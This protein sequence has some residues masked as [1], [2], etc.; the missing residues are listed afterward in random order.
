M[1]SVELSSCC[2][3]WLLFHREL[4]EAGPPIVATVV[5]PYVYSLKLGK[6]L[7]FLTHWGSRTFSEGIEPFGSRPTVSADGE[8]PVERSAEG[9]E[10]EEE[11]PV[12]R[13][14]EGLEFSSTDCNIPG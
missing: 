13:S 12:E 10:F 2:R 14:A 1:S 11:G 4:T 5:D 7:I 9:L 8:G 3:C 6:A